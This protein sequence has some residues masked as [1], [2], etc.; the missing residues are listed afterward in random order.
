[1]RPNDWRW[2]GIGF[3]YNDGTKQRIGK[4][5][6]YEKI[7]ELR[8]NERLINFISSRDDDDET[9]KYYNFKLVIARSN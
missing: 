5:S 4:K 1:V 7:V 6:N 3:C 2:C 8:S 9:I